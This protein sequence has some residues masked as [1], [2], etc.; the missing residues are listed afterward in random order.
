LRELLADQ[1]DR[2]ARTRWKRGHQ[3]GH[4]DQPRGVRDV[5]ASS[6]G[7][8]GDRASGRQHDHL[9]D[10]FLAHGLQFPENW[11]KIQ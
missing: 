11:L 9:P 6:S 4:A 3:L 5:V 2:P 1:F 8:A 10:R 7:T